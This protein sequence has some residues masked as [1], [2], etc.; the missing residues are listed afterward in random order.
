[1]SAMPDR[2]ASNP[3]RESIRAT[4]LAA[5]AALD[6]YESKRVLQSYGLVTPPEYL[7][8]TRSEVLSRAETVGYPVVLKTANGELHKS[9]R[10]GVALNIT[11]PDILLTA[12]AQIEQ[13]FDPRVLVQ[14]MIPPGV[15]IILGLTND[16]QFGCVL[17]LGLGGIFV[18]VF[19]DVRVL[20][21]PTNQAMIE[22][23]LL[24][25]KSAPLL[26]GARGRPAVRIS[27]I[28]EMALALASFATDCGDLITSVDINPLI[29]SQEDAVAVDAVIVPKFA[30]NG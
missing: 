13:T 5:T 7:A 28:V 3:Q 6:E 8:A 19:H 22:A 11:S 17:T 2:L 1:M 4:L 16:P 23:A 27:A 26:L 20:M 24:N 21:L 25:L 9:D 14:Q 30:P 18:E 12:Y 29:V 15:E 10:G